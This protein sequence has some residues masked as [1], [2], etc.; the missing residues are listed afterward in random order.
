MEINPETVE[1]CASLLKK[2]GN[3]PALVR[4]G[5]EIED[6]FI[7]FKSADKVPLECDI[8]YPIYVRGELR[9]QPK[10]TPQ[11]KADRINK[12]FDKDHK[13]KTKRLVNKWKRQGQIKEITTYF[14]KK[15]DKDKE[16]KPY[17]YDL[18]SGAHG[19]EHP[20]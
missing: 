11:E 15:E 9:F 3:A 17:A 2:D 20:V 18:F 13:N 6:S 12:F 8:L 4:V 10:E 7:C 19:H 5:H 1:L 14:G 16:S